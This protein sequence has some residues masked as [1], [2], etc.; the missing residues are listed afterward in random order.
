MPAT[1]L[2]ALTRSQP[3]RET[4][5]AVRGVTSALDDLALA[6]SSLLA[7][8]CGPVEGHPGVS[9]PRYLLLGQTG[10]D[11]PLR[12][13]VFAGIHGDQPET[14]HAA[15]EM[16]KLF[17]ARPALAE[18][19]CL[20]VYPVCNPTGFE[21]GTR[22]SARGR[23]LNREFWNNSSEPEITVLQSELCAHAFDGIITLHTDESSGGMYA[24]TKGSTF[25]HHLAEPALAAAEAVL[26]RNEQPL[27]EGFAARRGI[28]R[29]AFH[30]ALSAPPKVRPRPFEITLCAPKKVPAYLRETAFTLAVQTVL[31]RYRE[32]IAY[33]RHL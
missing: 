30:G 10:G 28:I 5:R 13:G 19:Y 14:S 29:E 27:I 18:G 21:A 33:A 17:E 24:F 7:K 8:P 4:V 26:P 6:S 31:T 16:L 23:D 15:A 1:S 25:A 9:L 3:S 12:V 32:L 2:T 20:F 22:C 11:D